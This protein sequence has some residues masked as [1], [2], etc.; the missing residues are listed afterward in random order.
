V[1]AAGDVRGDWGVGG[2]RCACRV[3]Q[4]RVR[5]SL[6]GL[7]GPL[8]RRLPSHVGVEAEGMGNTKAGLGVLV[9]RKVSTVKDVQVSKFEKQLV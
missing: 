1:E 7:G 4:G 5:G 8:A 6:A 3:V 2:G 9:K